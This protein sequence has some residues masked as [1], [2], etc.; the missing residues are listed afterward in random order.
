MIV[1]TKRVPTPPQQLSRYNSI[2][3]RESVTKKQKYAY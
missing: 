1:E 3:F 2:R